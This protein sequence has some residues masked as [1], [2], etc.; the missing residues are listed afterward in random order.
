MLVHSKPSTLRSAGDQRSA[1]RRAV[2]HGVFTAAIEATPPASRERS[3]QAWVGLVGRADRE[4]DRLPV[5]DSSRIELLVSCCGSE[6]S[7]RMIQMSPLGSERSL[8][9]A[10]NVPSGDHAGPSSCTGALGGSAVSFGRCA[11]REVEDEDVA[12][13]AADRSVDLEGEL[14][15]VG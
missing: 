9:N 14:G 3:P 10:I 13:H 8:V 4:G 12:V 7:A 11:G 15:A 5:G 1:T 6:P 2:W